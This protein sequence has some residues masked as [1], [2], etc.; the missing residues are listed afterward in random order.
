MPIMPIRFRCAYCNQLMAI[1]R[2][3][4]GTVVAIG[5]YAE[6]CQVHMPRERIHLLAVDQNFQPAHFQDRYFLYYPRHRHPS[7]RLKLET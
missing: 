3:K 4:A 5:V 2:R 7:I 6:P 1:A